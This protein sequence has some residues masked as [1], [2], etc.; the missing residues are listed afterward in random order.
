LLVQPVGSALG[1]AHRLPGKKYQVR[2]LI[3]SA[4]VIVAATVAGSFGVVDDLRPVQ[5]A[6]SDS[7]W[8]KGCIPAG[9]RH[10]DNTNGSMDGGQ[11]LRPRWP[12]G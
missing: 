12:S 4:D 11:P 7:D 10:Q 1:I 6:W 5:P 2:G 9:Q 3:A 8:T